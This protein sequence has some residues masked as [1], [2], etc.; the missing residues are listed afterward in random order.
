MTT[1]LNSAAALGS[2]RSFVNYRQTLALL[3][4]L[5][6]MWGFITVINNTLLPHLRAVFE[7]NYTQ[8]T[9]IESVWFIAYFIAS[10]PSAKLIERVGYKRSIV[11][12]LS[13]MAAGAL[14]M[15]PAARILSYRVVLTALFV[16]A[17]GITLLQVAANP[18]VAVIGRPESAPARLNLVQAFN[19]MGTTFAPLFG[20]Y[21]ILGRSTS[22]TSQSGATLTY[23]ERVADAQAVQLPYLIVA[24]VLVL[25][26][27]V[28]TRYKLP[29]LGASTRRVA[30]AERKHHSLW[31][32]RNLVLGVPAIF[33]YLIAEI[34]VSNLFINFVSAPDIGNLTHERASHYLFLLWGGMMM[35]R[36]LGSYLM[37]YV[38]ADRVLAVASI[39]AFIVVVVSI[40]AHGPM[41]M[42]ALISVG[43]FHSI[44]FPT[45]FTLGIRG[46]GP[47]TEEG[48]GILIMAIAGGALVVVQG[49]FAD[50]FGLQ[51]S[52]VL[53]SICELYVLF[54][55][56]WGSKPTHALADER[57]V[58]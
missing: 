47:L 26:A 49:T 41:A 22:G 57:L 1:P 11:I 27:V 14:L 58:V 19:S 39:G 44:M 40:V 3:A 33:I 50:L 28:I 48:S 16:I 43:L 46:L 53:T 45:I 36:F 38:S 37:R 25:L 31:R 42:W 2:S 34:G 32:H 7:L 54:Y 15:I 4:S 17:S 18:Y 35:G 29:D 12:G 8:T 20:G 24:A 52:F 5:F 21:L 6:F 23:A 13:I 51:R 30:A 10:I 9:L 55:A 56:L